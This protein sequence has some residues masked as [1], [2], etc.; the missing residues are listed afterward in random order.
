MPSQSPVD[1]EA[2]ERHFATA[3][4]NVD[5]AVVYH[6]QY[7]SPEN[8]SW[9]IELVPSIQ[10]ELESAVRS[11]PTNPEY[12][13]LFA[14]WKGLLAG[15][16]N[17]D[18]IRKIA[19]L[20][21]GFAEAAGYLANPD[22]WRPPFAY[23]AWGGIENRLPTFVLPPDIPMEIRPVRDG[24]RRLFAFFRRS[25]QLSPGQNFDSSM[26]AAIRLAFMKTPHGAVVGAYMLLDTDPNEPYTD[27]ILLNVD[28]YFQEL[29]DLSYSGYWVVRL[30]A[31]QQYTFVVLAD[32]SGSVCLNR[33]IEYDP[34]TKANLNEVAK[35]IE[36]LKPTS[37]SDMAK[38]KTA[39]KYFMEH[40]S[41][42]AIQF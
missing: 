28:T 31:Q 10:S 37:S 23:P 40:S 26:R 1:K 35:Q 3:S 5:A 7:G 22:K 2:A 4:V 39:Q 18:E 25:P 13:Y 17:L 32:P 29:A 21:P 19:G 8:I 27:E 34:K 38:R 14:C 6:R 15:K 16:P 11:D 12:K 20:H 9:L 33:R 30:L 36:L 41:M 24:C 42:N